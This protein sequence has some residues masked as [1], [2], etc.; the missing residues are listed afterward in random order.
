[1]KTTTWKRRH[2]CQSFRKALWCL[3]QRRGKGLGRNLADGLEEMA[4]PVMDSDY[5]GSD[6]MKPSAA[7]GK[8]TSQSTGFRPPINGGTPGAN[9]VI[10]KTLD[11]MMTK[12][13]WM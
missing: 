9:K 10:G 6:G 1:M 7:A 3:P 8:V 13:S 11:L 2:L 12:S 4:G 5:D